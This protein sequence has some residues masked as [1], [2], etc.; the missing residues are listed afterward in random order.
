MLTKI[1]GWGRW[2][3]W[4]TAWRLWRPFI[5]LDALIFIFGLS[6][7]CERAMYLETLFGT[8]TGT[9]FSDWALEW[10]MCPTMRDVIKNMNI[11]KQT[12]THCMV[13]MCF[14][15]ASRDGWATP[16]YEPYQRSGVWTFSWDRL[17][18]LLSNTYYPSHIMHF[19]VLASSGFQVIFRIQ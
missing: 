16:F 3:L 9:C 18:R 5:Y 6:L 13:G 4:R 11:H 12:W 19:N 7:G 8:P 2:F 10:L 1:L 17:A 14:I 15:C